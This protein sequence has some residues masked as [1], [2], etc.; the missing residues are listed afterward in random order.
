M[1]I[2]A[3]SQ[4]PYFFKRLV[5][6]SATDLAPPSDSDFLL[7]PFERTEDLLPNLGAVP[8]NSLRVNLWAESDW[9]E[10]G[11]LLRGVDGGSAPAVCGVTGACFFGDNKLVNF[12]ALKL[13][14]LLL[15]RLGALLDGGLQ[16][17]VSEDDNDVVEGEL[18]SWPGTS[19]S[20]TPATI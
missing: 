18:W 12:P 7:L 11:P 17:S 8:S 3:L 2:A 15:R 14:A 1:P 10:D 13:G 16:L 5:V 6:L 9:T 19:L 4:T 20:N